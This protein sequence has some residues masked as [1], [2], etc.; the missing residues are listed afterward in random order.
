M[1]LIPH[2]R[3]TTIFALLASSSYLLSSVYSSPNFH[4][5]APFDTLAISCCAF[6][7]LLSQ[8]RIIFRHGR[9]R[10]KR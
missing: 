10:F 3:S 1:V 2:E 9:Q 4:I 7:K 5:S 6:S 8:S